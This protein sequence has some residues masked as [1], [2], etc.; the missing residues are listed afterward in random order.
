MTQA[1]LY[2]VMYAICGLIAIYMAV[3]ALTDSGQKS[4]IG[5][6][7]FWGA[8]GIVMGLGKW[9]TP[10]VSGILVIVMALPAIISL[11][12]PGNTKPAADDFRMKM[13]NKYGYKLFIPAFAIGVSALVFAIVIP[14]L[15]A[16]VG[17][18]FGTVLAAVMVSV[19]TKDTPSII[20][21]E[22]RRMLDAVG[23]LSMLPQLLASLG[24]IFTAAGVG[25]VIAAGVST[26]VPEGNVFIGIVIYAVGMALFT[27]IMGNAFAAFSVI[28]VGIGVPFAIKYG[29]D[30]SYVGMLALT[31]GYCGTLMT[32]MAAN[33]NIVPVAVLEM[34][35]KYGVI[36]KQMPIALTMLVVQIFMMYFF[37]RA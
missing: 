37:G 36:K 7:V 10:L 2:E 9:L 24:A 1:D 22:G 14:K 30:P 6:A 29:L 21:N 31:S 23:P 26:V 25:K 8:L 19:M 32:P 35:D 3:R 16:L 12:K 18:G 15:G 33:F 5:T 17:L 4:R 13:A 28:T 27:M 20:L 34:K 11:V